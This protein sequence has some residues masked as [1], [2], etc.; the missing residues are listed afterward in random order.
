MLHSRHLFTYTL[1]WECIGRTTNKK[2]ESCDSLG[3]LYTSF[4]SVF[5]VD[6]KC[7]GV[8]NCKIS[9]F[10]IRE[11]GVMWIV[12]CSIKTVS[13]FG[14]LEDLYLYLSGESRSGG[15]TCLSSQRWVNVYTRV[16][17]S[18]DV[19]EVDSDVISLAGSVCH[20][21]FFPDYL[22]GILFS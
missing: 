22:S 10:S 17:V 5:D 7:Y 3:S 21:I 13:S 8:A 11:L 4:P 2:I 20:R 9:Y 1:T 12:F 18:M 6:F 19:F 16:F 15:S 14:R